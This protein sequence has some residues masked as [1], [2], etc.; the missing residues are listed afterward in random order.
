MAIFI[1]PLYF[2]TLSLFNYIKKG[3]NVSTFILFLYFIS[4][5]AGTYLHYYHPD[6]INLPISLEAVIHHI[7]CL[8]CFILPVIY[9]GNRISFIV[10]FNSMGVKYIAIIIVL[11][12]LMGI[13]TDIPK[14]YAV[15]SQPSLAAA[16]M[17]NIE[18]ELIEKS[19]GGLSSYLIA[20]GRASSLLCLF[21]FF[22]C[23][24]FLHERWLLVILFVSSLTTLSSNILAA[25]R[26]ETFRY[27]YQLAVCYL[28]F[29]PYMKKVSKKMIFSFSIIVVFFLSFV[30]TVTAS[31]FGSDS[32]IKNVLD[33]FGQS[34]INYSSVYDIFD[35]PLF[36][37]RKNFA[38]LFPVEYRISSLDVNQY[39][40]TGF[41]LN[42]FATLIGSFL[43][44]FGHIGTLMFSFLSGL[45]LVM[46][47]K[48][49]MPFFVK[50]FIYIYTVDIVLFGMFYYYAASSTVLLSLIALF[51][52]CVLLYSNLKYRFK[53]KV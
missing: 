38:G 47:F 32:V 8:S 15:F 12:S 29:R 42:V 48:L 43:M 1:Y 20:I 53:C 24:S 39:V 17:L 34:F 45:M 11:F 28:L 36:M 16:R 26:G 35:D 13:L 37:G 23:R 21:L 49:S 6:Y 5:L 51:F 41:Y 9:Y 7:I 33:Y 44:D 52:L 19:S 25:G 31:R 2:G 10:H 4:A 22:Y 30:Y 40:H 18:G 14:Y 46:F 3:L 27:I 50:V